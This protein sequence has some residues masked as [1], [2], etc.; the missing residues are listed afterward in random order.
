MTGKG[1][2]GRGRGSAMAVRGKGAVTSRGRGGSK[3]KMSRG[4][5]KVGAGAKSLGKKNLQPVDDEDDEEEEEEEEDEEEDDDDEEEE[6]EDDDDEEEDEEE[7]ESVDVTTGGKRKGG[8]ASAPGKRIK[9]TISGKGAFTGKGG[10]GGKGG[11]VGKGVVGKGKYNFTGTDGETEASDTGKDSEEEEEDEDEEDEDEEENLDEDVDILGDDPAPHGGANIERFQNQAPVAKLSGKGAVMA[12]EQK[13]K[14]AAAAKRKAE[15]KRR[16]EARK[17]ELEIIAQIESEAQ[18]RKAAKAKKAAEEKALKEKKAKQKKEASAK[19]KSAKEKAKAAKTKS[20]VKNKGKAAGDGADSSDPVAAAAA[21]IAEKLLS[22]Q[23][24]TKADKESKSSAPDM[25]IAPTAKPLPAPTWN[26]L[27]H[28]ASLGSSKTTSVKVGMGMTLQRSGSMSTK[29][30]PFG[31]DMD[32][33]TREA[34][35]LAT[36][37][38]LN[39]RAL[40]ELMNQIVPDKRVEHEV[41]GYL[42]QMADDFVERVTAAACS[43]ARH[44][45]AKSL[46]VQDVAL[47]LKRYWGI[48]VPGFGVDK[49]DTARV[50]PV[51]ES[52]AA[53]MLRIGRL[54][55][56]A[57]STKKGAPSTSA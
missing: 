52:H 4:G 13:K 30:S 45:G 24:S 3:G 17:K 9:G 20:K 7:E 47:H 50:L 22:E 6:E 32:Q 29:T 54:Q 5:G 18:K 55:A 25:D 44:R 46:G 10:K 19:A 28:L 40:R 23:T 51:S 8:S 2:R 48:S 12:L 26:P 38:L 57:S 34:E 31:K 41:E 39:R 1:S 35:Q 15:A 21:L 27:S 42:L 33:A 14:A 16:E 43:L 36:R 56:A 11:K 37:E 49:A 53:R